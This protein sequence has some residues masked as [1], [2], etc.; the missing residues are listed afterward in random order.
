[1]MTAPTPVNTA[2]PNKA[3]SAWLNSA[4]SFTHERR[5]TTA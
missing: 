2:Q 1:L 3:A 5:Y 4:S